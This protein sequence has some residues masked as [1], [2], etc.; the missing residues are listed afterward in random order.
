MRYFL[1]GI[2]ICIT[3]SCKWSNAELGKNYFYLDK[4][5]AI[6]VGY[7]GGAIIYKS[8]EKY[9]F[10]NIIISGDVLKVNS[11]NDFIIV[12]QRP[13]SETDKTYYYIIEKKGDIVHGPLSSDSLSLMKKMFEVK[14]EL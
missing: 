12:K 2:I 3:S 13:K 8:S 4:D 14:L 1:I 5:E 7:P 9:Y 6:D 11:D 10:K